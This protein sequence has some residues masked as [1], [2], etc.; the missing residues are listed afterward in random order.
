METFEIRNTSEG[1]GLQKK[2]HHESSPRNL[3]ILFEEFIQRIFFIKENGSH[4]SVCFKMSFRMS[5]K[6][7]F[8]F[9]IVKTQMPREAIISVN[10][11]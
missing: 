5:I 7:F 6:F 8:F 9:L 2:N 11:I 3:K 1:Y 4:S 10:V